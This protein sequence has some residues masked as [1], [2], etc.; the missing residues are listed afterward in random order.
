MARVLAFINPSISTRNVG[1]LFIEDSVK[2]IL[3]YDRQQS[4]DIDPRKPIGPRELEQINACEAAVIVGTNLWYRDM[5]KPS[6]WQFTLSDLDKIKTPIIPLGVG[7]TRKAGEDNGF[8]PETRDLIARLHADCRLGSAR[9]WRTV[10][11]LHEAGIRNVVMTGC[12]TLFRSLS[13]TWRLRPP[14]NDRQRIVVTVRKGQ[15]HNVHILLRMLKQRGLQ[16]V[17]AAQQPPDNFLRRGWFFRPPPAPTIFE[18]RLQPYLDLVDQ[19]LGAIGWRLHG[20]MF[21]LAHGNP[22]VFFANCSRSQSFCESF[23]LPHQF[24]SDGRWLSRQSIARAVEQFFDPATFAK[25]PERYAHYR[26]EMAAF[27]DANGLEHRLQSA[28]P[29]DATP[30]LDVPVARARSIAPTR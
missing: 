9:D 23:G 7:T 10:E 26:G 12:P 28:D 30:G 4:V 5:P 19:S 3:V 6:R 2:R 11:A 21:H 25:L 20:N 17:I 29:G 15:R 13:P 1:D 24:C 14:T 22:A 16:P 18:Q 8:T 27:L